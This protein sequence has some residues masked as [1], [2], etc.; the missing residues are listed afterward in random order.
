MS[1][2]DSFSLFDPSSHRQK[3]KPTPESRRPEGSLPQGGSVQKLAEN[4]PGAKPI[5]PEMR[6]KI[7]ADPRIKEWIEKIETM[8][9]EISEK[10]NKLIE[11][12]GHTPK[13]IRKYLENPQNFSPKEWQLI[14]AHR[15]KLEQSLGITAMPAFKKFK[16]A[17]ETQEQTKQRK[18]K[19][20]G[21]R[22][23]WID[24]H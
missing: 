11:L 15:E 12:K 9:Q 21:T 13:S 7:F 24:M 18:G 17:K 14:Q 10:V 1:S 20:L 23:N 8:H 22:K 19:T 3:K 16:K 4:L 2:K 6:E 5:T